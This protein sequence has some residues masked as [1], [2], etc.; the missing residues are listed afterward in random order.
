MIGVGPNGY[1]S[2][3]ARVALVNWDGEVVC[4]TLVK[5]VEPV[6]DYRTSVSGITAEDLEGDDAV[7][8]YEARGKVAE[9]IRGKIVVGHGLKNDFRVLGIRDHPW[10]LV[11]DTAKYEFFMKAVDPSELPPGV[12]PTAY[13]PKKLKVLAR[14]K[15]RKA[16][17]EEGR[18]HSPVEDATAALELYKKHRGKWE[19]A[20][21]YKVERTRSIT[22]SSH[23]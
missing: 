17:Q 10:H 1:Y 13:V 19:A 23:L 12:P 9:L 8:F 22:S 18:P 21:A 4:D 14:D 16:I 5:V 3:L 6:T 15:L 2:R 20:V 11:R 7:G